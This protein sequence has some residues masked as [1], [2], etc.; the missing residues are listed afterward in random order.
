M[1]GRTSSGTPHGRNQGRTT[2]HALQQ[3]QRQIIG[4]GRQDKEVSRA[5]RDRFQLITADVSKIEGGNTDRLR[6]RLPTLAEQQQH[7]FSF[8]RCGQTLQRFDEEIAT[9]PKSFK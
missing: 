9:F 5:I 8:E 6:D 7:D 3:A 2:G 1:P 4:T